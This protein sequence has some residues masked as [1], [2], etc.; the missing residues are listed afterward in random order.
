VT[1]ERIKIRVT[2]VSTSKNLKALTD[3]K[4]FKT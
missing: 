3:T 1:I 2:K 4:I